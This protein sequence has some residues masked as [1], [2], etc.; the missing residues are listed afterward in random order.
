[1]Y[2]SIVVGTDGSPPARTA[3]DAAVALAKASKATLHIVSAYSMISTNLIASAAAAGAPVP[4]H[5][6]SN[7]AEQTKLLLE[8]IALDVEKHGVELT[9]H[10]CSGSADQALIEVAKT[11][12]ADLIV[13]GSR[14]MTGARRILGSVP[15]SVAH[16]APCSVLIVKTD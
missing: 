3:V 8:E 4:M 1:M 15:N 10:P 16:K 9:T 6:G 12:K 11:H 14:G 7:E 2:S 5:T 13:V